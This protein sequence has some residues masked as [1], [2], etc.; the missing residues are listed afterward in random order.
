MFFVMVMQA[1]WW[2]IEHVMTGSIRHD[3]TYT[4]CPFFLCD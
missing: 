4:V 1:G 2:M 3:V